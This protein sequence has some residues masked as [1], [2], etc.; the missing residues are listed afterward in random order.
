MLGLPPSALRD[1]RAIVERYD[2]HAEPF[3]PVPMLQVARDEGWLVRFR[4]P[5]GRLYGVGVVDGPDRVML[6]NEAVSPA[7][8]RYAMAHELAHDLLGHQGWFTCADSELSRRVLVREEV[9]A[10]KGA[11]YLLVP[12]AALGLDT[13]ADATEM[14]GVPSDVVELRRAC[15]LGVRERVWSV[16]GACVGIM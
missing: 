10:N 1:L 6:I 2:L 9:D 3:C 5:M 7:W 16:L 8:Q 15:A 11:A 14:C 13:I 4:S 12:A